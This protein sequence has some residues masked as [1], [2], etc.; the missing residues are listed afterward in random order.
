MSSP[1]V[2]VVIPVLW[3]SGTAISWV[4]PSLAPV[5]RPASAPGKRLSPPASISLGRPVLPP[6]PSAFHVGDTASGSGASDRPASGVK[7]AG[8]L[9]ITPRGSSRPTSSA[10]GFSSSRPSSSASGSRADSGCGTAPSFHAA[11]AACIHSMELGST[12]VT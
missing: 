9:G 3:L 5:V 2:A 4:S 7:S 6:E 10:R 12:I 1:I 8:T 11:S